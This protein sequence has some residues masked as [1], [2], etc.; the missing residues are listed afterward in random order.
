M[1]GPWRH[2]ER[3][4]PRGIALVVPGIALFLAL[5]SWRLVSRVLRM[6]Q[7]TRLSTAGDALS[8]A[9]EERLGVYVSLLLATRGLVELSDTVSVED[10]RRFAGSLETQRRYPGIQGLG[11][12]PRVMPGGREE[13][14]RSMR[15]QG[16]AGFHVWPERE[17]E[18]F[19]VTI[20]MPE[21]WRNRRALG[22][23]MF[24]EPVRHAAMARA[25]RLGVPQ[26]SGQVLL[27]QESNSEPQPGFLLYVP[28]FGPLGTDAPPLGFVYAPFR[29][30]DLFGKLLS[31]TRHDDL[32]VRIS[33]APTGEVPRLLYDSSVD[34]GRVAGDRWTERRIAVF[35]RTWLV[36]LAIDPAY[37]DTRTLLWPRM[38]LAGGLAIALLFFALVVQQ[39][40]AREAAERA[41]ARKEFIAAA[42]LELGGTLAESTT[43]RATAELA[44]PRLGEQVF[45]E[46]AA[47]RGAWTTAAGPAGGL[48]AAERPGAVHLPDHPERTR[49]SPDELSRWLVHPA[50]ADLGGGP[51][52]AMR[53]PIRGRTSLTGVFV[54]L[55]AERPYDEA[56]LTLGLEYIRL[57]TTALENAR[58][59]RQAKQA[60]ALREE[61]LG[62][63]S[64]ELRTPL[65]SLRL[66]LQ[67][68]M[69]LRVAG[70]VEKLGPAVEASERQVRRLSI[71]V[72][73]LMDLA[74][75]R[76]GRLELELEPVDLAQL[77]RD[78]AGRL[79]DAFDAAGSS[80]TLDL[81]ATLV[82]RWDRLRLEQVLTNLLT[83]AA[84]YGRGRPVHLN[85]STVD[86]DARLAVQDEG[87][88]LSPED[89][90]RV[91]NRFERAVS[92]RHYGGLGLGLYIVRQMVELHGG[93]VEVESREGVG[94][95][96]TVRL[97]L[98]ETAPASA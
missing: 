92:G 14:K 61:F 91:F 80:L 94:S 40:A 68:A 29:S 83:N 45:V 15:E 77:C 98:P 19:P 90:S 11:W 54:A 38:T 48:D 35:G 3:H 46:V 52:W 26:L 10:F 18:Q 55:R 97:P 49:V 60:V 64:H 5:A 37:V 71:L 53:L 79:H 72:D 6:E 73:G 96:F 78:T 23:D 21:D 4:R 43:L 88:G 22:F 17:G 82:G 59:Y 44:R 2:W 66:Q 51:W 85:L 81:P 63:A 12:A 69:R 50:P 74:R 31:E 20:L 93:R 70:D 13:L 42:G 57:A 75:I 24:S 1:R 47:D 28:R 95:T 56:D 16:L 84:K 34:D 32:F 62:I 25:A 86:G 87:I 39:G 89:A 33:D 36:Q 41:R 76:H 7:E 65:T 30:F 58:L 67:R 8:N 27:F 9:I